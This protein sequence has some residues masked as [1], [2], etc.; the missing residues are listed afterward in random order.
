MMN[1]KMN[2]TMRQQK[3]IPPITVKSIFV[4]KANTVRPSVMTVVMIAASATACGLIK[5]KETFS[6]FHPGL[7]V[8]YKKLT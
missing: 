4:W 5:T 3:S 2:I 6:N 7:E 8:H 1:P